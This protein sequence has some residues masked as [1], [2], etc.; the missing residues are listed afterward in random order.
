MYTKDETLNLL[1]IEGGAASELFDTEMIAVVQDL[2]DLNTDA[3]SPRSITLKW[4]YKPD[5][6]VP[7]MGAS[8]ITVTSKLGK[9][10]SP[11]VM[12]T[13]G[14]DQHGNTEAREIISGQKAMF[15]PMPDESKVIAMMQGGN[16]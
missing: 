7:G 11:G 2:L 15:N 16:E 4:E 1:N 6:K 3:T 13:I 10:T 9:K 8:S 12:V 5:K 14:M